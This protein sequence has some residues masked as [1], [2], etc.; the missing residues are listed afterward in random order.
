MLFPVGLGGS[1]MGTGIPGALEGLVLML[2]NPSI[3]SQ[4]DSRLPPL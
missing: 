4:E 3:Q 2:S 1:M